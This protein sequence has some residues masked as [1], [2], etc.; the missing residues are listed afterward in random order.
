[1]TEE[2]PI[3]IVG[4]SRSGTKLMRAALAAHPRIAIAP[5]THLLNYWMP[6]HETAELQ[7]KLD[8]ERFWSGFVDCPQ[9][10]NLELDA[11]TLH[12]RLLANGV[13]TFKTLFSTLLREYAQRCGKPRWGETTP[14]HHQCVENLLEWYPNARIIYMLRDPRAVVASLLDAPWTTSGLEFHAARWRDSTRTLLRWESDERICGVHYEALVIEP[15]PLLRKVCAFLEEPFDPALLTHS[16][17]SLTTRVNHEKWGRHH[18]SD[19][20]GPIR[21]DRLTKWQLR[22]TPDQVAIVEYLTRKG[23]LR[24]GYELSS[25]GPGALLWSALMFNRLWTRLKRETNRLRGQTGK[26]ASRSPSETQAGRPAASRQTEENA[27]DAQR[28][29][30]L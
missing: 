22:L 17:A 21:T 6:R 9:F 23:M 5:G 10:R 4:M 14:V 20:L 16:E 25:E 24:Y 15:E 28:Q 7:D 13:P 11:D 1:M 2:S 29:Q 8:F 12:D 30:L 3:F 19:A 18:L 27:S 26:M